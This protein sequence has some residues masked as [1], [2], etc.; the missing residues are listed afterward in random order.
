MSVTAVHVTPMRRLLAAELLK[1]RSTRVVWG[2]LAG[3]LALALLSL[4][5]VLAG[6]RAGQPRLNSD[7]GI[8]RV[9][10][11]AGAGS[12]F[13]LALGILA[14][15]GELRHGTAVQAF[16]AVPR[17]VPVIV[18]K[19][20]AC[21]L[22]GLGFGLVCAAFC[23]ALALPW[24]ASEGQAI[25]LTDGQLWAVLAG[26]VLSTAL[27]GALGA[28]LGAL[29]GNQVLG[30]LVA[31]GWFVVVESALT[32]ALPEVGKWLPGGAASALTQAPSSDDLLAPGWGG[33]LLVAYV[34]AF[35]YAGIAAVRRREVGA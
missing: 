3:T 11:S 25:S 13:A 35:A 31:L 10:V 26:V 5:G 22:L 34:I 29:L 20:G 24:S 4:V 6:D 9:F 30:L 27:Y 28:G 8:A 2:L 19:V 15:A 1:V 16:L 21:A 18:A 7:D 12:I 33:L 17:R 14:S 23:V 32:A